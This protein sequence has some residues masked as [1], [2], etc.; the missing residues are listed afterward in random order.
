MEGPS[1]QEAARSPGSG[2]LTACAAWAPMLLCPQQEG[3]QGLHRQ[4]TLMGPWSLVS[5]AWWMR[6]ISL[7]WN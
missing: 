1:G 3:R 5:A 4:Q 7:P 2:Q 6:W